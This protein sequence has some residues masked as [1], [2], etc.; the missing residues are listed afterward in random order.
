MRD[1]KIIDHFLKQYEEEFKN[2]KT[3]TS[4]TLYE[5]KADGG[6]TLEWTHIK[7]EAEYAFKRAKSKA[8]LFIVK[9]GRKYPLTEKFLPSKNQKTE[10]GVITDVMRRLS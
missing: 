8:M 3:F 4:D 10:K 9:N 1:S 6:T 5:V 7:S 2:R